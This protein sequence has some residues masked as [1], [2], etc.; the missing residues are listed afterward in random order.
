MRSVADEVNIL[1]IE[2]SFYILIPSRFPPVALFER[3]AN[4]D[5]QAAIAAI[6]S[7]T[8]PRLRERERVLKVE[9]V[10]TN[11]PQLQN[12]NHAPFAY[13]NPEGT[14]FFGPE[15]PSLDLAD[16]VQTALAISV[17]KRQA[18][19]TR[20]AEARVSLDMRAIARPVS[21]RFADFR[22]V[23]LEASLEE[24]RSVGE[25][26][27]RL[28]ADGL[29]YSP[30]ERPSATCVAVLKPTALGRAIQGEHF[31]FVWDG[32]RIHSLYAFSGPGLTIDTDRL[33]SA[34]SVLAA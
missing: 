14:R 27:L 16:N 22:H 30:P 6:E 4:D 3:I 29:L 9:D 25:Q 23:H 13:R 8:N 7:L 5:G 12:W 10:E 20:T 31:R 24:R 32:K 1:E 21:G 34:E 18:F 17:G 19:L 2:Q 28:E 11:N 26:A 33:R 15:Q